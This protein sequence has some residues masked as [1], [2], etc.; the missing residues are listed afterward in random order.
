MKSKSKAQFAVICLAVFLLL[1]FT[2]YS[3][4]VMAEEISPQQKIDRKAVEKGL[5][6]SLGMPVLKG[7][8]WMKM[9]HD[10]KVA[11]IWGFGHVVSIEYYLME[12]FPELKRDSFVAKAVVGMD[13]TPMNEVVA[14]VDRY[15]DMHPD[16]IGKPVTSVLWDT[17]IRPN[18][19][20]GIAG[21]PLKSQ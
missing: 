3:F 5:D 10:E 15:Y 19:R 20:T 1:G 17:M 8:L 13:N 9:T 7:D 16:D 21:Q 6:E 14:R 18:I 2:G 4:V 11:F 12:K